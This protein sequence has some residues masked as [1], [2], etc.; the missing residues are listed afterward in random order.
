MAC[1]DAAIGQ[2]L[3]RWSVVAH[4][5]VDETV[6]GGQYRVVHVGVDGQDG[7]GAPVA[8]DGADGVVSGYV[9]LVRPIAAAA[10]ERAEEDA[11]SV[12]RAGLAGAVT[13]VGGHRAAHFPYLREGQERA[14]SDRAPEPG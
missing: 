10:A 2:L 5:V 3:P 4:D 14:V 12:P 1:E 9:A 6:F 7:R 8:A 11:Q 13:A